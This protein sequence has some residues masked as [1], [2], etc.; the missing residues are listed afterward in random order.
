MKPQ[1]QKGGKGSKEYK[2]EMQAGLI[3]L[4]S[5]VIIKNITESSISYK[6]QIY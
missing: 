4:I 5:A 1:S 6:S 2:G 3:M